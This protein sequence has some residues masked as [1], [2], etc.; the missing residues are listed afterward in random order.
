MM[1]FTSRMISVIPAVIVVGLAGVGLDRLRADAA[2]GSR[3]SPVV[4]R[5]ARSGNWSDPATWEGDHAPGSQARVLIRAGHRV[6]Y[7]VKSSQTIRGINIAGT[8]SFA[9]DR[10]TRLDVGLIKI[11]A[12]DDYSE[13]GFDCEAHLTA[14]EA[15]AARAA[16]EVGTFERPIEPQHTALI[17][18]VYIN[19]MDRGSCPAI[20]CCAARMDFHGAVLNHAWVKLGHDVQAHDTEITLAEP[21]TGWRAGDRVIVTA[22]HVDEN[23]S[24]TR[25]PG[26]RN[27]RVFTEER[28][29]RSVEGTRLTI[30]RPTEFAHAGSGDYRAEVANLSRNVVVESADPGGVRGH[31]MYH[32]NSAGSISY[33]EFRHLGKEGVLGRYA[34]HYHLVGDTMR[35]S[36]VVGASIWD[37]ANRWLTI[38]GTN[39]LIV[40]DC[41]GYESVG[42]GFFLENGAEAYNVLDHN[43]A[44]Q[45]YEGKPLPKQALPFDANEGAGF[46]WA[47]SL[48]TFTRNVAC[49]NDRYGFRFEATK[50]SNFDPVLSVLQP[51]GS[52]KLVDIRTLPFVRFDD[53]E[54]H[55]DGLYGFNLGEGVNRVGP[56]ARHPF[57]IRRMKLW[58]IHYAFRPESPCVLV[59]DMQMANSVYGVYHPNYDRHVYR[60][61]TINGSGSEPFNRGHDD[62][63]I[64]YG[65]LTVDGLT[66]DDVTGYPE[67]IPLIQMSD[68]NPTGKA[69]SHFRNV[70]VFRRE[71]NNRRPVVDTGG[72]EHVTPHTAHGV[73]VYLHDYYGPNRTA[74]AEATN[75]HDFRADG[76]KYRAVPPLTGH[77]AQVA[78]VH[79]VEFPQLL[80]PVDDLA[81][82]TVITE[83]RRLSGN[84]ARVRGATADNGIVARVLVNGQAARST[85]E[86]FS[87]W[88]ITLERKPGADAKIEAHAE[89]AAGNIELRGHVLP[90]GFE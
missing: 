79:D 4:V 34:L 70:K 72:G 31:T 44:V 67:S 60:N 8:L 43:L 10:D 39:Y 88:E 21:V 55:C 73:P 7:D 71:S 9:T 22:S 5:S 49:E 87:Q 54:A 40:R 16:L 20:V 41:V 53:N 30:D 14:P 58:D 15:G 27:R 45:A 80:D 51:D 59:E 77:E 63:S 85:S 24:G 66:F 52:D 17:R 47:N 25:R 46:W 56:D 50:G 90:N 29:I 38:H 19:G 11:Q 35:G 3:E 78:E 18:L 6:V 28:T 74:K 68:D 42:H 37:S 62:D 36:S 83:V 57:V 76:L 32:R 33:A 64:Q 65:P 89:D 48:N 86:N 75:A 13:Q 23:E 2:K 26:K 61:M 69:V 81:P 84:K 12:G 1:R 82:T